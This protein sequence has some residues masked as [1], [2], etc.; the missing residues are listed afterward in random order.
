MGND[1][2]ST[3]QWLKRNYKR[4]TKSCIERWSSKKGTLN[5]TKKNFDKILRRNLN[6]RRVGK[7]LL[8]IDSD[9]FFYIID[10]L[11]DEKKI[12]NILQWFWISSCSWAFLQDKLFVKSITPVQKRKIHHRGQGHSNAADPILPNRLIFLVE[13]EDVEKIETNLK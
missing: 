13:L 10:L 2:K 1:T 11:C 3:W 7:I 12:K 8:R 6:D 4:A 9:L 5:V